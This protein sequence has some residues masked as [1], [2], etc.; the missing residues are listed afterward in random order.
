M[1]AVG[2]PAIGHSPGDM[3]LIPVVLHI[4]TGYSLTDQAEQIGQC[5]GDVDGENYS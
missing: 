4:I 2:K 5:E 1:A 3:S